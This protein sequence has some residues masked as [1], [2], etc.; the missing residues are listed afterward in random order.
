MLGSVGHGAMFNRAGGMGQQHAPMGF[1]RGSHGLGSANPSGGYSQNP[2]PPQPVVPGQSQ[3]SHPD[4]GQ[5]SAQ[6]MGGGLGQSGGMDYL[7]A[8]RLGQP[9]Q[10]GGNFSPAGYDQSSGY[11]PSEEI[12]TFHPNQGTLLNTPQT[13]DGGTTYQPPNNYQSP[14]NHFGTDQNGAQLPGYSQ[15]QFDPYSPNSGMYGGNWQQPNQQNV[16][17]AYLNQYPG[18]GSV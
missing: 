14:Y 8:S 11:N 2:A 16:A 9:F 10:S 1:G 13:G 15:S 4:L 18:L 7:S 12:G 6:P 17:N 3:M 5:Q